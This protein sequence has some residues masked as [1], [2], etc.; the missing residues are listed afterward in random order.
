MPALHSDVKTTFSC[1]LNFK[2]HRMQIKYQRHTI[3]NVIFD[4]ISV[5]KHWRLAYHLTVI[6]IIPL[7]SF[8][9]AVIL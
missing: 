9:T 3:K 4:H 7:Y 8:V 5:I 2:Q 1:L 6:C